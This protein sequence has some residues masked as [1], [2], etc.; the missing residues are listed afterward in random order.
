MSNAAPSAV[1]DELPADLVSRA[2]LAEGDTTLRFT[3]SLTLDTVAALWPRIGELDLGRVERIDLSAVPHVDSAGAALVLRARRDAGGDAPARLVGASEQVGAMLDVL[4]E[5]VAVPEREADA[6]EEGLFDTVGALVLGVAHNTRG[7]VEFIGALAQGLWQAARRPRSVRWR[8]VRT[9]VA[10]AGAEAVGIVS[11]I[12]LL[13]GVILAFQMA[14]QMRKYGADLYV[15][16]IVSLSLVREL[17]PLMTAILVA[18]RSGSAFAAE[19]GTMTVNEEVAALDTMGLERTRFLVLPKVAAL[20]LV[21]PLLVMYADF[22]GISGGMIVAAT[23]LDQPISIY[24]DH[25]IG[26]LGTRDL[27]E[28]LVKGE[29]YALIIAAVGC[30]R[31]LQTSSG[32]QGVGR[33]ATSAV[34]TSIFL[35]IV[36]D[37]VLTAI[38]YL[39]TS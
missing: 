39:L 18:G 17:G 30:L 6:G 21:M 25:A 3:G 34:V 27:I 5:S 11:L 8:E 24:F 1:P 29:T 31:G 9:Y 12:G 20:L 32:A 15:A 26:R 36:A 4:D 33:S 38:F 14:A 23:F 7:T 2:E 37:A 35:V 10:R 22:A 13:M 19:I 16:D 28:G